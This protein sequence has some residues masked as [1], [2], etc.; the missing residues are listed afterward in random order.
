[1]SEPLI[2][3]PPLPCVLHTASHVPAGARL[4]D[5]MK[6]RLTLVPVT[7]VGDL[8]TTGHTW[9]RAGR[10]SDAA[11][12]DWIRGRTVDLVADGDGIAIAASALDDLRDSSRWTPPWP[13]PLAILHE[14]EDLVVL[15]KPAQM[16]VHPLGDR[17]EHTLVNALVHHAG[18]GSEGPWALWRP[19]AVQR[20]DFV[21]SGVIA[22]AKS[23]EAKA[24]LV[25]AQKRRGIERTYVAL[26][27][28]NIGDDR[29]V[30]DAPVGR[31]PG[32]GYRR[33][34][35]RESDGG[36]RAVTRWSVL[37]RFGDSTLVEVAPETGR[38]H[39]IRVHLAH[40]GHPIVGDWLYAGNAADS[41]PSR[42]GTESDRESSPVVAGSSATSATDG[43]APSAEIALH[44]IRL[45][46]PHPRSGEMVTVESPPPSF[47]AQA[48]AGG[49][50]A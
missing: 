32:R 29:G 19:H 43:R 48:R 39:Q 28:G 49:T 5:Y 27:R 14:D 45:R 35:V 44:A 34:I 36:Q 25:R 15:N 3:T 38:T 6:S 8:I 10:G 1:M 13:V 2:Q 33:A 31:E 7:D 18:G 20:L 4:V 46:L 41:V 47:V 42:I 9:I 22:V 26:V 50:A 17:R 37:E 40:L 30:V 16:H 12:G 21:V 11:R 24:S 23:A